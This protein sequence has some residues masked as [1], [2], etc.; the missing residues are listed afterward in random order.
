MN[1]T[2]YFIVASAT[3]SIALIWRMILLDHSDFAVLV[4]KTPLAGE[5]LYCGFCFPMWLSLFATLMINPL[6]GWEP[7]LFRELPV[8][9][10]S[11]LRLFFGWLSLGSGVLFIRFF[12]TTLMD[13]TGVLS[14]LHRTK[15]PEE[16]LTASPTQIQK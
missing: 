14:H 9:L 8:F 2:D 11:L 13:A 4:K 7:K 3:A 1:W 12:I 15:H 10:A 5:A 6:A 16:T